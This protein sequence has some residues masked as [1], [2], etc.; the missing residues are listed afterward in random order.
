MTSIK[1]NEQTEGNTGVEVIS[2]IERSIHRK[3]KGANRVEVC[4]CKEH[5]TSYSRD[6]WEKETPVLTIVFCLMENHKVKYLRLHCRHTFILLISMTSF[7]LKFFSLH[8]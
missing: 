8:E 7:A 3:G 1:N 6:V 2:E 4:G 5:I